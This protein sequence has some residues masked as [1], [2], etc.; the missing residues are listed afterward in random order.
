M[1][2]PDQRGSRLSAL[3]DHVN[4]T[5]GRDAVALGLAGLE[6][7]PNWQ[8]RRDMLPNRGTTRW[9]ELAVVRA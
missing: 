3:I 6:S 4:A 7:A 9:S 2:E 1:V 8:M 5:V